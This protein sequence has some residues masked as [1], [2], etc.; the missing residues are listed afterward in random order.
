MILVSTGTNGDAF[1]R[2]LRAVAALEFE[3]EL[4]VQHGPSKIRP[5]G[6]RCVGYLSFDDYSALVRRADK[7]IT[8]AGVGSVLVTLMHGKVPLVVPRL[9][10]FQEAIDDHQLL[11]A[12]RLAAADLV[13]LVDDPNELGDRLRTARAGEASKISVPARSSLVDELRDYLKLLID[14]EHHGE[15][16][17]STR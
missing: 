10:R 3:T 7:V 5:V 1:D 15:A 9:A 8:H 17:F 11:F 4:V 2:L 6:A 14:T 16:G 12:R 13:Q